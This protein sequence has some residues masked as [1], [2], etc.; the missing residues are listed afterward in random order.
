[1]SEWQPDRR[2]SADAA[3]DRAVREI[4]SAEPRP[5]FKLRVLARLRA[6][7]DATS[8]GWAWP[9]VAVAAIGAA[10]IVF[11]IIMS[12]PADRRPESPPIAQTTPATSAAPP[13]EAPR[14][15]DRSKSSQTSSPMRDLRET[16][17]A[18]PRVVRAA[19][20][21]PLEAAEASHPENTVTSEV[22]SAIEPI[23][24]PALQMAPIPTPHVEIRPLPAL[25]R[26]AISPLSPL[27]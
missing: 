6:E 9:R 20:L 24:V 4:M 15:A 1:M 25:D 11:V 22:S 10:A 19:S 27:R 17:R 26:I 23:S 14:L 8:P 21:I 7:P 16:P 12:R 2:D 3:I 5:G 18:E 13:A